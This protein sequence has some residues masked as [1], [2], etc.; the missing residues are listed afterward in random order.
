MHASQTALACTVRGQGVGLK[1]K[2]VASL[3]TPPFHV[4]QAS[5]GM[6]TMSNAEFD[7]GTSDLVTLFP[8]QA[9]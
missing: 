3:L 7:G 6:T 9:S 2:K 5:F 4:H 1:V 8:I